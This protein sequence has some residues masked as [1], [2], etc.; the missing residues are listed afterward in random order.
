MNKAEFLKKLGFP[1]DMPTDNV[2]FVP[3]G[4]SPMD[5]LKMNLIESLKIPSGIDPMDVFITLM[6]AT[7]NRYINAKSVYFMG[8]HAPL[9]K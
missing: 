8:H 3:V 2:H 9:S 7:T 5:N 4:N 1:D 6:N